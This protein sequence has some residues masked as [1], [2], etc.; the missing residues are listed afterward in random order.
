MT[1]T[2]FTRVAV[3]GASS[4]IGSALVA[5]LMAQGIDAHRVGRGRSATGAPLVHVFDA[6]LGC[7]DPALGAADAVITL[8]PLPTIAVVMRMARSLGARRV[9][10]FGS[11]GRYS[12]HGSTSA[13]ER[14]FSAQQ[15]QA[16][17]L[18]VSQCE[19]AGMAWTLFRPT[20]VYGANA[21][22]NVAFIR[23]M[24]LRFGFFP[25][26]RGAN[27][28]RQPVHVDDLASAC[29]AALD[30]PRTFARA[31]DLGG[32]ETLPFPDLVRRVSEAVG[33]RP[34]VVPIPLLMY[35]MLIWVARRIPGAG[36]VRMEMVD[37]MYQD[38]VAD[39][40]PAHAD[41]GYQ[42]R[43]FSLGHDVA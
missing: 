28:L 11:T 17:R 32:G 40:G 37:R 14:N 27:G 18:F 13:I 31:Y 7:F 20:M 10:A 15:E 19:A 6:R 16:E 36:F 29:A 9:I 35:R 1:A 43:A 39:N 23:T 12:K 42:P 25:L 5:R 4:Q 24:V 21:D 26:P 8:A 33:G 41:F 3:V 22:L 30:N 38:L 34:M 2:R